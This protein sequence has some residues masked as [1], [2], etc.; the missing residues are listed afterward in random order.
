MYVHAYEF[1]CLSFFNLRHLQLLPRPL[2][3]YPRNFIWNCKVC[4]G[5]PY[6]CKVIKCMRRWARACTKLATNV[7]ERCNNSNGVEANNT[8]QKQ[9]CFIV[10]I[11]FYHLRVRAGIQN[12]AL[13]QASTLEQRSRRPLQ[14]SGHAL[15]AIRPR[16][17]RQQLAHLRQFSLCIYNIIA[18]HTHTPTHTH[19]HAF[20]CYYYDL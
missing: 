16:R 7:R 2:C 20:I 19:R 6:L 9:L 5:L 18:S 10:I 1:V 4:I 15:F 13:R 8:L 14:V 3:G 17:R 11:I 12:N